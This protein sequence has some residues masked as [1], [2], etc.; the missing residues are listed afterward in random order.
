MPKTQFTKISGYL[1]QIYTRKNIYITHT[2]Q[3]PNKPSNN[4]FFLLRQNWNAN[5]FNKTNLIFCPTFISTNSTSSRNK[6]PT[7][8]LSWLD[9]TCRNTSSSINFLSISSTPKTILK[10]HSSMILNRLL[11]S[12]GIILT[13]LLKK[14]KIWFIKI[15]E[16]QSF[17]IS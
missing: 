16:N 9:P 2:K 17:M 5:A 12:P 15:A 10:L 11:A 13:P 4:Q 14:L 6:L 1:Y 7:S 8:S 3:C